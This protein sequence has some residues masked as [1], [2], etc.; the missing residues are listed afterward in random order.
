MF[1]LENNNGTTQIMFSVCLQN[2]YIAYYVKYCTAGDHEVI[3]IMHKTSFVFRTTKTQRRKL[4]CFY[5]K[6]WTQTFL[7]NLV[8]TAK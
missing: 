2:R 5:E 6:E 8:P 4:F 1:K 7:I 3:R